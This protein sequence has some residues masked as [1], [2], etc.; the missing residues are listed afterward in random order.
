M[1]SKYSL[2]SSNENYLNW[3][4]I[5]QAS[6]NSA[7]LFEEYLNQFCTS[8]YTHINTYGGECSITG[9]MCNEPNRHLIQKHARDLA[10]SIGLRYPVFSFC[11][12]QSKNWILENLN[13]FQ[14]I[15]RDRYFIHGSHFEGYMPNNVIPLMINAG[16]AF[17]SG[18]HPS[19]EGCLQALSQLSKQHSFKQMIDMGCGSGILSLAMAKTWKSSVLACDIDK[20]ALV[21][22]AS[23]AKANQTGG[24]I[25]CI[26]CD[27]YKHREVI[28]NGPFDLITANI[29]ALPLAKLAK[30]LRRIIAPNGL[31]VLSGILERDARWIIN[32]HRILGL[33]LLA[34]QKING[35]S[36]LI[37]KKNRKSSHIE[38]H[39]SSGF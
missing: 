9:I 13:T 21:V 16:P 4:V 2:P 5:C 26:N 36:T 8:V 14:P 3:E 37:L 25:R 7:P 15:R 18:E 10:S 34:H 17:G 23:N 12:H 22:T 33:H 35:W 28:R 38:G 19:T 11:I 6:L 20:M 27:G 30:D 24:L 32:I 1:N 31:A 39:R 29:F